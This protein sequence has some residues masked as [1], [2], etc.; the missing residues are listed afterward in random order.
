MTKRRGRLCSK[1]KVW[2]ERDDR[3]VFG[4]GKAHLLEKIEETGSLASAAKSLGMS[5]RGLW[6]R[7][8]EMEKRLGMK[9]IERRSGG[10]HGGGSQL[11][12]RGRDLLERYHCFRKGIDEYVDRRF[13]RAFGEGAG[14]R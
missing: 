10:I 8:A 1:S 6:G 5:Y 13:A 14:K 4:D 12:R 7:L 11:T 3:P 2:L 9:L